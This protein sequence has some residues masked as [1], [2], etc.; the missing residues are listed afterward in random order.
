MLRSCGD[1]RAAVRSGSRY[2]VARKPFNYFFMF[3]FDT[4]ANTTRQAL[5]LSW[6]GQAGSWAVFVA[7]LAL[8]PM[9]SWASAALAATAL[10]QALN[11]SIFE[12]PV[13]FRTRQSGEFE[14]ELQRR[15]DSPGVVRMP[16]LI[17]G[18]I[19]FALLT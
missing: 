2:R 15:L 4:P 14:K 19:F 12:I 1:S 7:I 10:G 9:D 18:L 3:S 8:V 17:A 13:I 5:W 16:G 6:G 11:A